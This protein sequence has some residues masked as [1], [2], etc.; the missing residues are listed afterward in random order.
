MSNKLIAVVDDEP[1]ITKTVCD[2]LNSNGFD[3]RGFHDGEK[4]FEFLNKEI[5]DLAILDLNLPGISGFDICKKLKEKEK[6]ASI[7]IIILSANTEEPSKV[8][9]LDIGVDD[10]M[11]KPFSLNELKSRIQAVLRRGNQPEEE[12]IVKIGDK[13]EM[14]LKKHEVKVDGKK[15]ELTPA[16]FRILEY[17]SSRKGQAFTRDRILDYLWGEEKVVVERT[18]DVHIRHLREKLGQASS[19]IVNVRGYGYKIDESF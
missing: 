8:F 10:Y 9:G 13:I 1:D 11:T 12:E 15:I 17:L 14:D 3:A 4:F 19:C 16:E 6:F 18:I 7:P 2:Y 5:P